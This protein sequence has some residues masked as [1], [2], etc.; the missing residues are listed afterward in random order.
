MDPVYKILKLKSGDEMICSVIKE[1]NNQV[2]LNLPMVF[3]TMI[4]PDPYNGTQKEITVLRDWVSYTKDTEVSLPS[5]YILT[6]TSPEDDVISLYEKEV[7]KKLSDDQPKRKVQNYNDAK[8][9]LQEELENMLD[10]MEAEIDNPPD[11]S[12]FKKWGMIPMNEEM[13][14][15]MMEGLNF[16]EGEGIDFEFEF[17]FAPEEI[18]ADESTEDELNHPDFGNRWT[19]WSSNPKEY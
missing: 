7:E 3:K 14:R 9:N 16:P 15:Q 4:I 19:D 8:K 13:L 10:E 6:Y 1:E 17:N 11:N 18:N 2:Y 12:N 5:D